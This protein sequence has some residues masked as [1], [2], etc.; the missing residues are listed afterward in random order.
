MKHGLLADVTER[1]PKWG[2]LAWRLASLLTLFT[3]S[4]RPSV[5]RSL[6]FTCLW[7]TFNLHK[8]LGG[9]VAVT[10]C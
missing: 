3:F 5:Q 4:A 6:S 1:S 9:T 10:D 2:I 7:L 8:R